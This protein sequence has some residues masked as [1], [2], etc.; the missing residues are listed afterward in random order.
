MSLRC[1]Y[2]TLV[3][4]ACCADID[5]ATAF[6]PALNSRYFPIDA[7]V[8]EWANE[9]LA[10]TREP[11]LPTAGKEAA[12]AG[13]ESYCFTWLRSF[14]NPV[15]VRAVHDRNGTRRIVTKMM[16]RDEKGRSRDL[17]I[18]KSKTLNEQQWAG[19]VERVQ[20]SEFWAQPTKEQ[21][22]FVLPN[23]N[24]HVLAKVDGAHW[25]FEAATANGFHVVDR[26]NPPQDS[27]FADLCL[28]LLELSDIDLSKEKVY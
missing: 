7:E 23:G 28:Y 8:C 26:H 13:T 14:N 15:V 17:V 16:D 12:R 1:L 21:P 6:D 25:V 3:M 24:R 27:K 10:A 11:A 20:A 4:A 2:F 22:Q 18:D 9:E 19:L 5:S